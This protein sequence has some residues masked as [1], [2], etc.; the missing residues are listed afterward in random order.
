MEPR[1]GSRCLAWSELQF[2][3]QQNQI[4]CDVDVVE[5]LCAAYCKFK[6]LKAGQQPVERVSSSHTITFE[7]RGISSLS[8]NQVVASIVGWPDN[9][10]VRSQYFEGVLQNRRR[11][12]WTIAIE[13]VDVLSAGRSELSTNRGES[14]GKALTVLRHD[15]HCIAQE[16]CQSSPVRLRAHNRDFHAPQGLCQLNR[17]P[18]QAAIQCGDRERREA[19]TQPSLDPARFWGFRHNHQRSVCKRR[20][21]SGLARGFHARSVY[22]ELRCSRHSRPSMSKIIAHDP[23]KDEPCRSQRPLER[24]AD[25]GLSNAW[26]IAHGDFDDAKSRESALQ[27]HFHCPAIGSFFKGQGMQ[28]IRAAG[29]KRTE[30]T[31]L[32]AVQ[33]PD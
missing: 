20:T 2:P 17:I 24:A 19:L 30:V 8:A 16:V 6:D 21:H 12:V 23:A 13:R 33:K 26:V 29:A 9:Y 5:R 1:R 18:Q 3:S 15:R 28:H 11:K 32:H 14:G 7:Q 22:R 10:V 31:D 25:L 27:D 4:V